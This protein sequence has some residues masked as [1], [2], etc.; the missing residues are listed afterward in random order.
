LSHKQRGKTERRK[1]Q[2]VT[3][4]EIREKPRRQA[5]VLKDERR[6]L[7]IERPTS[8]EKQTSNYDY[9]RAISLSFQ[10]WCYS[11]S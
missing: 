3:G 6:T 2:N 9:L 8:N 5:V 11:G 7:N 10:P 1:E 4:N